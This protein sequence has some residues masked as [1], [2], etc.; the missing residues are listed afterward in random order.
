M[1]K[2]EPDFDLYGVILGVMFVGISYLANIY[3]VIPTEH[4]TLVSVLGKQI[5]VSLYFI[6]IC[7]PQL[8]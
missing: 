3:P 4:E 8:C 7:R 1:E 6:S 5:F 2:C